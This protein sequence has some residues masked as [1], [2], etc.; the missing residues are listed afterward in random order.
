MNGFILTGHSAGFCTT[1]TFL[2]RALKTRET[3][4]AKD[5][6]RGTYAVFCTGV[7]LWLTDGILAGGVSTFIT[8][9]VTVALAFSILFFKLSF[10]D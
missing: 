5:Q 3:N 6:S 1:A 10:K 4:S 2:P 7:L 9:A 8:N